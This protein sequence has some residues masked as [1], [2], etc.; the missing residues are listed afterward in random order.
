MNALRVIAYRAETA[1]ASILGEEWKYPGQAR[2]LLKDIFT[3][4]ADLLPDAAAG[5]LTVR[6]HPL[7]NQ[8]QDEAAEILA[9]HLNDTETVFPG[10]EM[11][12]RFDLVSWHITVITS[13]DWYQCHAEKFLRQK[14][15]F[16]GKLS[17]VRGTMFELGGTPGTARL[18][19]GVARRGPDSSP[20]W[21]SATLAPLGLPRYGKPTEEH[22]S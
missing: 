8:R 14:P 17:P 11:V 1:L 15:G 18:Q 13:C 10:T 22:G 5:M 20:D 7:S 2:S 16:H 6:L 21:Q 12:M 3:A 4:E 19:P 9:R